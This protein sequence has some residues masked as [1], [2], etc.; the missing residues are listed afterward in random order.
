MIDL[1]K[2]SGNPTNGLQA[3]YTELMGITDVEELKNKSI[4]I[5][6]SYRGSGVSERNCDR[7][8]TELRKCET[9]QKAQKYVSNY[10][11]KGSGMGVI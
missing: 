5:M 10:I 9:I 6:E 3:N 4:A 7:F 1:S 8:V 11:L 2:K